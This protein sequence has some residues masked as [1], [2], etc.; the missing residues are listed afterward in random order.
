MA[1]DRPPKTH[2]ITASSTLFF[3]YFLPTIYVVF[4]G[5]L[6]IV[7]LFADKFRVG[8]MSPMA[9]KIAYMA[10]FVAVVALMYFTLFRL[11]RVEVDD[12]HIYITN[13]LKIFRYPFAS[14][15]RITATDYGIWLVMQVH[16][17]QP[18]HFGR[19]ST[20]LVHRRRLTQYLAD[21]PENRSALKLPD[22]LKLPTTA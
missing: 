7:F 5:T 4:F 20:F 17:V 19:R 9:F 16:L 22:G 10:L 2:N 21:Y 13:Y 1:T 11:K 6:M 14:I 8:S 3:K 18:G 15:E 12:Q